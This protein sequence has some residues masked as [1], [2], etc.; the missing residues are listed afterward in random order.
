MIYTKCFITENFQID[1]NC[2]LIKLFSKE[3]T[4]CARAGQFVQIKIAESIEPLLMRPFSFFKIDKVKNIFSVLYQV[5]GKGT[6]KLSQLKKNDI[7][8]VLGPLGNYFTY[9]KHFKKFVLIAGGVG[10]APL[11]SF[12]DDLIR[13]RKDVT[14]VLGL[15]EKSIF[16]FLKEH[17]SILGSGKFLAAI[18]KDPLMFN[19]TVV[20]FFR[21]I[22]KNKKYDYAAACGPAEML[23]NLQKVLTKNNMPVFCSLEAHLACGMGVCKGCA[24]K[25][26]EKYKRVCA[27]GPIFDLKEISW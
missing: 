14:V 27:D 17:F 6:E 10:I 20:D 21:D 1:E 11:A 5:K 22:S 25:I 23:K 26:N 3:I 16:N 2:F 4:R 19:G 13:C 18:E 24:V 7:L 8:N 12:A 15:R 9:P